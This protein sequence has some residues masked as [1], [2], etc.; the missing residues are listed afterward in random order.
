MGFLENASLQGIF[1]VGTGHASSF[2][3]VASAVI[4]WH[5]KRGLTG[6]IEYIPF[7][8]HLKGCYQS[9]TQADLS[10]LRRAGYSSEFLSI[11]AGVS[12]YLDWLNTT[13]QPKLKR[14]Q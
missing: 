3:C 12:H 1:N 8:D 2:N 5:S 4:D 7:P 13:N 10:S 9:Y 6:E 14:V 11:D